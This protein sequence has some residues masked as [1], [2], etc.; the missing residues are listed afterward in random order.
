MTRIRTSFLAALG[1]LALGAMGQ[2]EAGTLASA[3]PAAVPGGVAGV[4]LVTDRGSW[5]EPGKH[6]DRGGDRRYSRY[7][8]RYD[9]R[10]FKKKGRKI[11]KHGYERGYEEGYLDARRRSFYDDRRHHHHRRYYPE[12]GVRGGFSFGDSYFNGGS[13]RFRY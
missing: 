7:D 10:H 4:Q 12:Y 2:A 3:K 13:F 11:F 5:I 1:L 6:R 9:G 8:D